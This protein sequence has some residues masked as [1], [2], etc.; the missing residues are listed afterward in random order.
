MGDADAYCFEQTRGGDPDRFLAALFA[1]SAQRANLIALYAFNLE[2]SRAWESV[3]EPMIGEIRLQW[4]RE[5]IEE[6]FE[7][8]TRRHPVC[9]ALARAVETLALSR[10]PFLT[11]IE[12]HRFD[13]YT[14]PMETFA[15]LDRYARDTAGSLFVLAAQVLARDVDFTAAADAAGRAWTIAYIIRAAGLHAARGRVYLPADLLSD[16]GVNVAELRAGRAV[17]ALFTVID[18]LRR[19]AGTELVCARERFA[20]ARCSHAL[21]AFLPLAVV[22]Q[23]LREPA[24]MRNVTLGLPPTIPLFR[25]Q[26]SLLAAALRGRP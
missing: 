20:A 3:S 22:P 15:A 6:I 18:R 21:P 2:V 1:P 14:E 11:L 23:M 25:R 26:I 7:G 12:A 10:A 19:D 9:E 5:A 4:W 24:L 13:V 16:A 17:P 8:R